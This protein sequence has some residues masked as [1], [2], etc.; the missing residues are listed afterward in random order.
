MK[1]TRYILL[2][3]A[4]LVSGSFTGCQTDPETLPEPQP[5]KGVIAVR[6]NVAMENE[7]SQPSLFAL[8][9]RNNDHEPL[10]YTLEVWTRETPPPVACCTRPRT[11]VCQ[12]ALNSK[13]L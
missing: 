2:G 9:T 10:V 6:S 1:L 13:S 7:P 4:I 3:W 8:H 5:V 11:A 12:E